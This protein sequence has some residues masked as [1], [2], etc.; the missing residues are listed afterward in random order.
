MAPETMPV[1][2]PA[3]L[4]TPLDL[5]DEVF[6]EETLEEARRDP[7]A[8]NAFVL[9]DAETGNSVANAPHHIDFQR[10]LSDPA[11]ARC[12]ILAFAESGKTTSISV[13]RV[14]WELGHNP[15]LRIGI[16][17]E[18]TPRAAEIVDLIAQYIRESAPTSTPAIG[19]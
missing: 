4:T 11:N 12:V 18:S 9:R 5:E 13:G 6:P 17:C 10:V 15:N 16:L 2:E 19:S 7:A 8:F 1:P 14:L 3:E